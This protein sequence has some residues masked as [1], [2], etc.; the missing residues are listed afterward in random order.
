MQTPGMTP[1][2]FEKE[3]EMA[4]LLPNLQA[5]KA[6][7]QGLREALAQDGHAISHAQALDMVAKSHGYQDWN[8]L[9]AALATAP[10][11]H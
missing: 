3:R 11:R 2:R 4:G 6:Q 1:R 8:T 9:H 10:S 5:T 7:A